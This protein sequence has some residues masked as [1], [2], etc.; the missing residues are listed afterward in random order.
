[1]TVM[2]G[3]LKEYGSKEIERIEERNEMDHKNERRKP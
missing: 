1:M 2:M 3:T